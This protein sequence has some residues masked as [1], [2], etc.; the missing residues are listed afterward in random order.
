[1]SLVTFRDRHEFTTRFNTPRNEAVHSGPTEKECSGYALAGSPQALVRYL[2]SPS[3]RLF[4]DAEIVPNGLEAVGV[5][6]LAR[7]ISESDCW[8]AIMGL[9]P[10]RTRGMCC[11]LLSVLLPSRERTGSWTYSLC[12]GR[13]H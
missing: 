9:E 10:C 11:G 8:R 13:Q 5:A 2:S 7:M 1:M 12:C 4:S 6:E 3:E